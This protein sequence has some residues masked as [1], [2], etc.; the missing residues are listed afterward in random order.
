MRSPS[1]HALAH[2]HRWMALI[3]GH[4]LHEVAQIPW[5]IS[6]LDAL[7]TLPADVSLLA[8]PSCRGVLSL[9]FNTALSQIEMLWLGLQFPPEPASLFRYKYFRPCTEE[10]YAILQDEIRFLTGYHSF[11]L[12]ILLLA[13]RQ[14]QLLDALERCEP[15]QSPLQQQQY[16]TFLTEL[17]R[18]EEV[19]ERH[20]SQWDSIF[21]WRSLFIFEGAPLL[22]NDYDDGAATSTRVS[23]VTTG[24]RDRGLLDMGILGAGAGRGRKG[25]VGVA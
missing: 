24:P 22:S 17:D 10:N 21:P 8:G 9:M 11:T 19:M 3:R 1:R 5:N 2:H 15:V 6:D 7:Q 18:V 25:G 4:S 23:A 13:R 12:S 16:N 20:L 14:V